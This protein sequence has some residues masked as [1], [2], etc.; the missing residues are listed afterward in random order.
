MVLQVDDHQD[1]GGDYN[2]NHKVV[3]V[4]MDFLHPL[5]LRLLSGAQY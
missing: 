4:L 3:F 2:H 5:V 1:N